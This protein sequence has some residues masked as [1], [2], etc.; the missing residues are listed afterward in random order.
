MSLK[1]RGLK[2]KFTVKLQDLESELSYTEAQNI[3]FT[4]QT[5]QRERGKKIHVEQINDTENSPNVKI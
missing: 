1:Y 2:P 3:E 5:S 4:G